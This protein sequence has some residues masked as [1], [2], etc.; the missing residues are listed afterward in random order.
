M[1][2]AGAGPVLAEAPAL[3][4]AVPALLQRPQQP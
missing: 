1:R 2:D 4:G 3:L